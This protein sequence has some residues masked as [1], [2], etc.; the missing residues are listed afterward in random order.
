MY[1]I[2]LQI[3]EGTPEGRV[4][5]QAVREQ[6]ISPDE[7][8]RNVLRQRAGKTPAEEMF[9][10]FSSPEDAALI[11]EVMELASRMRRVDEARGFGA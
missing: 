10:A 4:I 8:V 7:A 9:G 2:H 11:D 3:D 5:E 1:D 6:H